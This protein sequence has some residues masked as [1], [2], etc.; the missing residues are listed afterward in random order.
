MAEVVRYRESFDA[1]CGGWTAWQ[2]GGGGPRPLKIVDGA[3]RSESPW[4]IDFNHAPPGAGYLHLLYVLLTGIRTRSVDAI[5]PGNRFQDDGYPLDF[6]DATMRVRVRGELDRKGSQ[7]LLL[8]QADLPAP[9]PR[10]NL[11]LHR[12]P[13]VVQPQWTETTLT[14]SSDDTA[15]T[16]LGTC[17]QNADCER[18]G[19]GPAEQVLAN[20]NVDLILVLFPLDVAPAVPVAGDPHRLRAGR[21]YPVQTDRLPQGWVELDWIE[22]EYRPG[23]TMRKGR[24]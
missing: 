2:A 18:Y 10:V 14:L 19:C 11:V 15:W 8:V 6:R 24:A 9:G 1:G 22:W 13:I 23:V 20:L 16:C 17:G 5:T 21:D 4:G 7:L 3:A 12:D